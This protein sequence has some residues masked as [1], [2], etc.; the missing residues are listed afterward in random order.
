MYAK[1]AVQERRALPA[2]WMAGKSMGLAALFGVLLTVSI[3]IS[4]TIIFA[5][6]GRP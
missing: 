6:A 5:A 4:A 3:A 1:A 2:D